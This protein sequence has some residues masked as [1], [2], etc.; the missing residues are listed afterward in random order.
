LK[1]GEWPGGIIAWGEERVWLE[2]ISYTG[3]RTAFSIHGG[4]EFGSRGCIDLA[5]N[6]SA[7][8][9][10]LPKRPTLIIVFVNYP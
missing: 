9:S 7:F 2:P 1:R 5:T 3:P 8:F 10:I 4:Y 6:G